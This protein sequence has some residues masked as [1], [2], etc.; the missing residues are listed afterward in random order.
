M[1]LHELH[2]GLETAG[3]TDIPANLQDIMASIV[4][5]GSGVIDYTEFLS[6]ALTK[7][8]YENHDALWSAFKAFDRDGDGKISKSELVAVLSR[9]TTSDALNP[10][11]A[12]TRSCSH[13]SDILND[14]DKDGDGEIDF[15]EFKDMMV[16]ATD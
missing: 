9:Q 4:S 1:G 14:F 12:V 7:D 8:Q 16:D 11:K 2:A 5:D 10:K 13:V 6:A 3:F 15:E